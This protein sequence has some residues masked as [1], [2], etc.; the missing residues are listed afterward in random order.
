MLLLTR[1]VTFLPNTIFLNGCC[2]WIDYSLPGLT[3][4]IR[5]RMGNSHL[6]ISWTVVHHRCYTSHYYCFAIIFYFSVIFYDCFLF[7]SFFVSIFISLD[8]SLS[9]Q[10]FILTCLFSFWLII[11]LY[12]LY[13]GSITSCYSILYYYKMC[14]SRYT[15][16]VVC[17]M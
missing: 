6:S 14:Y 16:T 9:N 5:L 11:K 10:T 1:D 4:Q 13:Y 12:H 3:W 17:M 15:S 8:S 2:K 7:W